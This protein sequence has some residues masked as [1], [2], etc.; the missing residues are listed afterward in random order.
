MSNPIFTI[1]DKEIAEA[2]ALWGLLV[3]GN[4]SDES[5]KS[6][7]NAY[8]LSKSTKEIKGALEKDKTNFSAFLLLDAYFEDYISKVS[9][10]LMDILEENPSVLSAIEISKQ[11]RNKL[12]YTP[13]VNMRNA[14]INGVRNALNMYGG[15][16]KETEKVLS[17]RFEM[18]YLLHSALSSI[19]ELQLNQF[20][21]GESDPKDF[22]PAYNK[23][24]YQFWDVEE[25]LTI[26]CDAPSGISLCAIRDPLESSSHFAFMIRN[27]GNLFSLSDRPKEPHPLHKYMSRRPDRNLYG[28]IHENMFPYDIL[29]VQFSDA[30]RAA[31]INRSDSKDLIVHG[32]TYD[33]MK[34]I[35]EINAYD[36]IWTAIMFDLI[37]QR[38]W[39]NSYQCE[40]IS[41]TGSMIKNSSLL[42]NHAKKSNLPISFSNGLEIDL[43]ELS[44]DDLDTESTTE[45]EVGKRFSSINNW[46]ENR[47]KRDIKD[48]EI[49]NIVGD[50][51]LVLIESKSVTKDMI[52]HAH[53][54]SS[55]FSSV[56]YDVFKKDYFGSRNVSRVYFLEKNQIGTKK[57]LDADRKFI[58]RHH[59]IKQIQSL[60]NNDYEK[61]VQ[62]VTEKYNKLIESRKDFIFDFM[63]EERTL[64]YLSKAPFGDESEDSYNLV[65]FYDLEVVAEQSFAGRHLLAS[66]SF[67]FSGDGYKNH[68]PTCYFT[69]AVSSYAIKWTPHLSDDIAYLLDCNPSDIHEGLANFYK[70][71]TYAGNHII[72]RIDP[73]AKLKNP[74]LKMNTDIVIYLS[75]RGL[76]KFLLKKHSSF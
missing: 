36:M 52:N 47:F 29:D 60:A 59:F 12:S 15:L 33:R 57:Q 20:L 45:I 7:F 65:K 9:Y 16:N 64:P 62:S 27:G 46:M 38:F 75:K 41:F 13:I 6:N 11:L 69:G 24:I 26:G 2:M 4:S 58:A 5:R 23:F 50:S 72:N 53:S 10:S 49:F 30:D 68:Y 22:S 3:D 66:S 56:P 55:G 67:I 1:G 14:F 40:E 44:A 71:R 51:S 42:T 19:D 21:R 43:P 8:D 37:K 32:S 70:L 74:W 17:N 76:K 31:Y 18:S 39:N 25:M 63:K 54:I 48:N 28:R 73:I 61:S 34:P 35:T